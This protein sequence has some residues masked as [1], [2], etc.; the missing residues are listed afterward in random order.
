MSYKLAVACD[1]RGS[2]MGRQNFISEQDGKHTM[3]LEKV[4]I[5]SGG[6]DM[7]GAYWGLGDPLY[8][9]YCAGTEEEIRIF[10]RATSRDKAKAEVRKVFKNA[11][12]Y[13]EPTSLSVQTL[14]KRAS[15]GCRARNH[16]MGRYEQINE[17]TWEALCTDCGAAVVVDTKPAPNGID[18]GGEAVALNCRI[19]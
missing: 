10:V 14:K 13:G 3:H 7:G 11:V 1:H 6:Y 15:E 12:F 18:I 2:S 19:K 16:H 17:H 5:N 9:S 4:L 8:L